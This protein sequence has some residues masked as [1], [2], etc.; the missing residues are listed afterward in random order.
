REAA[1]L[2]SDLPEGL[3]APLAR[4]RQREK[5]S[6]AWSLAVFQGD[7]EAAEQRAR[8]IGQ[9]VASSQQQRPHGFAAL[10]LASVLEEMGR[11]AE[12]AKVAGEFLDQREAWEPDPRSEDAALG[13]DTTPMLLRTVLH[14]GRLSPAEVTARR[15]TWLASWKARLT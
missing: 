10:D 3:P 6:F 9:I 4:E 2:A 12:A 7:F 14:G 5:V 15:D 1:R 11:P 13:W 8:E